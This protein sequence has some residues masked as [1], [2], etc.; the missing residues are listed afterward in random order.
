MHAF[1][2][3]IDTVMRGRIAR[4]CWY[5]SNRYRK[6]TVWATSCCDALSAIPDHAIVRSPVAVALRNDG[7][8]GNGGS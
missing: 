3:R 2:R 7:T 5:A 8:D 4:R 6:R 1:F